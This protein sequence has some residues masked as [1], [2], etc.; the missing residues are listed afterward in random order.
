[1]KIKIRQSGENFKSDMWNFIRNYSSEVAIM[2][3][4]DEFIN[5]IFSVEENVNSEDRFQGL[6]SIPISN[7]R[8]G[9]TYQGSGTRNDIYLSH[10]SHVIKEISFENGEFWAIIEILN[11][12]MGRPLQ[13]LKMNEIELV[14]IYNSEEK[15][16]TFDIDLNV[17]YNVGTESYHYSV[18]K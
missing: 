6:G 18:K 14:S 3:K 16:I 13:N 8:Y 10:S 15:I 9:S 5:E 17:K 12:P 1:M 4:R 2:L 11:T 7:T